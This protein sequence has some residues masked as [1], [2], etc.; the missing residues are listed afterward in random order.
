MKLPGF[1]DKLKSFAHNVEMSQIPEATR[2]LN[3]SLETLESLDTGQII[4][5]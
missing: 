1:Y 5:L 2:G 3:S 4:R